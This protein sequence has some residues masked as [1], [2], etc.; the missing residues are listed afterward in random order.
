MLLNCK[1]GCTVETLFKIFHTKIETESE[2]PHAISL[3][4]RRYYQ[5]IIPSLYF[6]Q[7]AYNKT[8]IFVSSVPMWHFL[9]S[10]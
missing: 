7:L 5:S 3:A 1:V 9:K 6:P 8:V 4:R 10:F 2:V